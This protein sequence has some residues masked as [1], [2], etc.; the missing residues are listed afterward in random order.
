MAT[1]P[2]RDPGRLTAPLRIVDDAPSMRSL[3]LDHIRGLA[4][5]RRDAFARAEPFPHLVLDDLLRPEVAHALVDEFATTRGDWIFYHH[6]NERKRGFNDVAQMG[7]VARQ[8]VAD[9]NAPAFVRVS[10]FHRPE[11]SG[12]PS[13]VRGAGAVKFGLPSAVRGI[14]GVG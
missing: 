13:A 2:S 5:D 14:P 8:V 11:K 1:A 4:H 10:L 6:V 9:L 3:D 7:P 12:L